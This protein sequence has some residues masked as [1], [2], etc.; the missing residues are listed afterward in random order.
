MGY[1]DRSS[2]DGLL[3]PE[4]A[5]ETVRASAA[6]LQTWHESGRVGPRPPGRLRPH[7]VPVPPRWQWMLAGP[8]YRT[9][10][11]PDSRPPRMELHRSH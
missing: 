11:D 7:A 1:L 6:A 8:A 9:V 3:D 2:D 4:E 5:V 10:F